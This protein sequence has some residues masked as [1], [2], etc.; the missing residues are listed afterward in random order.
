MKKLVVGVVALVLVSLW[1]ISVGQA[2][3]VTGI[4][5]FAQPTDTI[6]LGGQ[7]NLGSQATFE[8]VILF[9]DSLAGEGNIFDEWT[10]GWEDKLLYAGPN[11]LR[12]YGILGEGAPDVTV[13]ITRNTWHHVAYEYDGSVQRLYLDGM[14]VGSLSTPS[15]TFG[16]SDGLGFLG[17]SP[18]TDWPT[19]F[20]GYMDSFRISDVARYGG[21]SFTPTLGDFSSDANTLVLYNFNELP[22]STMVTDLSG[23]GLNGT[24]GVGFDGATSPTFVPEPSTF[25]LLGVGAI[26]VFGGYTW[27]RRKQTA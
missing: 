12:G 24:L 22:G 27:R 2:N 18:H 5:R 13:D 1:F 11:R 23:H 3:T 14:V 4:A 10:D 20:L 6:R 15:K 17:G 16:N 26:S 25:V 21:T 7:T 8:A 19:G 9:T